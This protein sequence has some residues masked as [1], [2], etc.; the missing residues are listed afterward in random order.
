MSAAGVCRLMFW[1]GKMEE[2][3]ELIVN[4]QEALRLSHR[5]EPLH[6]PL[7]SPRRLMRIF[8][9]IVQAFVLAM[10]DLQRHVP[11]GRAIRGQFVRDHDAR[12]P[13]GLS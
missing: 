1:A 8:R 9:S 2:I 13:G 12:R 7:S 10:L 3:G 5:F 4:G 11:A 6:D